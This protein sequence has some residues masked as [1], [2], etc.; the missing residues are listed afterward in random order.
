MRRDLEGRLRRAEIARARS[1]S[2]EL[3][4]DQGNGWVLGP[5]GEQMTREQ[6]EGLGH[7]PGKVRIIIDETDAQL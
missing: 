3:W 1:D 7:A 6:A 4:I 5:R 2:I